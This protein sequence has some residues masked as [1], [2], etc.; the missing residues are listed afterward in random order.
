MYL[1][2]SSDTVLCHWTWIYCHL[3]H[4]WLPL[5][6]LTQGYL[7][8]ALCRHLRRPQPRPSLIMCFDPLLGTQDWGTTMVINHCAPGVGFQL[9]MLLFNQ[10]QQDDLSAAWPGFLTAV[11]LC[12]P[13]TPGAANS[14]H[15]DCAENPLQPI[16]TVESSMF[17]NLILYTLT[18]VIIFRS[19]FHWP[20]RIFLFHGTVN[21]RTLIFFIRVDQTTISGLR[22]VEIMSG[23]FRSAPNLQPTA[24]LGSGLKFPRSFSLVYQL[25]FGLP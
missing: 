20:H 1:F 2:I 10:I 13:V 14:H 22:L 4:V 18:G 7:Q 23:N 19:F 5:R 15:T 25:F 8:T 17:S 21:S 12:L 6:L 9:L 16:S 11:L 3:Y 24:S